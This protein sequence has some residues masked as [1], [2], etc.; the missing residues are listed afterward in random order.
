MFQK[1]TLPILLL[2]CLIVLSCKKTTIKKYV[3]CN[4]NCAS[5]QGRIINATTLKPIPNLTVLLRENHSSF[6]VSSSSDLGYFET[7]EEGIFT[8]K[9]NKTDFSIAH[10]SIDV[11]IYHFSEAKPTTVGYLNAY[12]DTIVNFKYY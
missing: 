2:L 11:E 7:N 3:Y 10:H 8:A 4:S 9:I 5:F 1:K 12:P 6:V